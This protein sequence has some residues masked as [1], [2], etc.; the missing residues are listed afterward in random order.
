MLGKYLM[1][2]HAKHYT[3]RLGKNITLPGSQQGKS[4]NTHQ[5]IGMPTESVNSTLWFSMEG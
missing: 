5:D 1:M 3:N 2:D 4:E